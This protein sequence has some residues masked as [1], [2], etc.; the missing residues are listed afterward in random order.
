MHPTRKRS[1]PTPLGSKVRSSAT[2]WGLSN[3][4]TTPIRSNDPLLICSTPLPNCFHR[5]DTTQSDL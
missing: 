1:S 4:V 5:L 2:G 3:V